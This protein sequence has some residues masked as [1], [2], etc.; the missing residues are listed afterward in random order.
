MEQIE[1]IEKSQDDS[2]RMY[3][4]IKVIT[5]NKTNKPLLVNAEK[6]V[7]ADAVAQSKIITDHF[8][9]MFSKDEVE[10]LP[11]ILPQRMDPPFQREEV[12]KA[13]KAL[14]NNRSAGGDDLKAEQLKHGPTIVYDKITEILNEMAETGEHPKEVKEG[15][16]I[17]L[18]KPGKPQGPPSNLRPI[19]LL[20]M[21]RK[22][23]ATLMIW[24]IGSKIDREI[25][26]SQ[27]AYRAGRGTTE[28]IF[29]LKTMAEKSI[30][31]T[32]FSTH[33]LMMD[34]SR[35]FDTINRGRVIEDLRTILTPSELH[36]IKL[37]IENV[38]LIVDV[39]GHR[40]E[41][42]TTNVGT[43]QGDCL[44]P[45]LFTLYLAKTLSKIK[46]TPGL[47]REVQDHSYAEYTDSGVLINLQYADDI[48]WV[49]GNCSGAIELL[50]QQIPEILSEHDLLINLAKTEEYI[51]NRE[52]T[53]WEKC[54]Y[55]GSTLLTQNDIKRR[56][57]LANMAFNNLRPILTDKKLAT[58]VK[59][60]IFGALIGSIFLYN[61][62]LWAL[63]KERNQHIDVCQRN[64]LRK[65]LNIRYPQK[66]SNENLYARTGQT[67]WSHTIRTRRIRWLGH[68]LRLPVDSPAR[69]A[70]D[71]FLN[72]KSKHPP[73]ARKTT[74][75][76]TVKKD[77][78]LLDITLESCF[79]IAQDRKVWHSLVVQMSSKS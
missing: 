6:G 44:S 28:Q 27:A 54:K 69:K 25:P 36:I 67:P 8:R 62:E 47:P 7:T 40:G 76:D 13:V 68:L 37:L 5:S 58:T 57:Q 51:V 42:F 71:T 23:L 29:T 1:V 72:Y 73:G 52:E 3:K 45:V 21:L 32:N 60:R 56:N 63:T 77:L 30:T 66:I 34:M 59:M 41:A 9:S 26:V 75:V 12:E 14:K 33:I 50:K 78:K 43:P 16:L 31:T 20:S 39:S 35:A 61:S 70:L 11:E 46:E 19:I 79:E 74:W 53:A 64:L 55:L 49:G 22:I 18:Q 48:C 24:R 2:G 15:I 10:A 4:A 17:P 38:R 65:I